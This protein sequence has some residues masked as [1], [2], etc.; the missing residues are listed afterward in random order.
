MSLL[1]MQV[2]INEAQKTLSQADRVAQ[3]MGRLLQGRLKNISPYVLEQLKREL[4]DFNMHTGKW[5]GE[6]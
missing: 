4:R 3:Q 6:E 1:D 5:R 2:A